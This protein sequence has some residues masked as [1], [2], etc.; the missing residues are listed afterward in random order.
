MI[1]LIV[2]AHAAPSIPNLGISNALSIIFKIAETLIPMSVSRSCPV[3]FS[4]N[5]TEPAAAL[6]T[7]PTHRTAKGQLPPPYSAPKTNSTRGFP[8]SRKINAAGA[9]PSSATRAPMI[10][11]R[12]SL[13]MS[14]A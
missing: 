12:L 10:A 2:V 9:D 8:Q 3:I 7:W 6:I 13:S 4:T 1:R 5:A 11:T 14:P